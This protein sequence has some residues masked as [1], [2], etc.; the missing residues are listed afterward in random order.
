DGRGERRLRPRPR[1]G[2]VAAW[3]TCIAELREAGEDAAAD[4]ELE[5]LR[6]AYPSAL[7]N[8]NRAPR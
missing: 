6:L 3:L 2:D 7:E 1:G 8:G 5:A 4:A